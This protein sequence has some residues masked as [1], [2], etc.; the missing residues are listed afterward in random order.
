MGVPEAFPYLLEGLRSP[1]SLIWGA[2]AAELRR[3]YG[4]DFGRDPDAW[5][6]WYRAHRDRLVWDPAA[7]TWRL[8]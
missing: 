5:V 3:A 2:S 6:A 1:S 7:R 8:E 4:V